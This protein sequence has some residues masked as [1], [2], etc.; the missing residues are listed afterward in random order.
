MSWNLQIVKALKTIRM[1]KKITQ[2]ELAKRI[3]M[4]RIQLVNLENSDSPNNNVSTLEK[5]SNALGVTLRDVIEEIEREKT[6]E[7]MIEEIKDP[8]RKLQEEILR[9]LRLSKDSSIEV[10]GII[11]SWDDRINKLTQEL[12]MMREIQPIGQKAFTDRLEGIDPETYG[13]EP[14]RS[15][16]INI[17]GADRDKNIRSEGGQE[18]MRDILRKL[19]QSSEQQTASMQRQEKLLAEILKKVDENEQFTKINY[20]LEVGEI[21]VEDARRRMTEMIRQKD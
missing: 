5:I 20:L 19:L 14:A 4:N 10:V 17:A 15:S 1:R 9:E 3:G 2:T 12:S 6:P 16:I 18:D 13:S 7:E 11:Q 8:D 21:S